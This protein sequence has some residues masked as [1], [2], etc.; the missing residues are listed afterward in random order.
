MKPT[1]ANIE[2]TLEVRSADGTAAEFYQADAEH[3]GKALRFL[4]RPRLFTEPQFVL[5]SEKWA[6]VLA[7]RTI[8]VILARTTAPVP[9]VLPL[10]SPAGPIDISEVEEGLL[11]EDRSVVFGQRDRGNV[12]GMNSRSFRVEVRTVGGW[13]NILAVG[14]QIRGTVQDRRHTF[15]HIFQ[16][17]V[18]P[19]KLCTGGIGFINPRNL[20][21]ATVYPAP[22]S[23]PD[24]ALPVEFLRWTPAVRR[25][26][27]VPRQSVLGIQPGRR[28]EAQWQA[29][30]G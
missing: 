14:A 20:T 28:R 1:L 6:T 5:A 4:S 23:L 3:I 27:R 25:P 24:T 11:D 9:E 29:D 17:P 30:P 22:D 21:R 12:N 26:Q 2:L 16:L 7:P 15:T 8:D 18:I 19:F 13:T 10:K